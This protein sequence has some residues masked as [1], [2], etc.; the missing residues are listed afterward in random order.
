MVSE[1]RRAEVR[2]RTGAV[3]VAWEGAGGARACQLRGIPF[4][5]IR[6]ISDGANQTAA[7]DFVANL[8]VV[9]GNVASVVTSLAGHGFRKMTS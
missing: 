4:V 3:V 6:G 7:G 8:P 1:E 5:E 9:M 2:T